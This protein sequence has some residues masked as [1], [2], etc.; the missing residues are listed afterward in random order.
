MELSDNVTVSVVEALDVTIYLEWYDEAVIGVA[1]DFAWF[2][3][4]TVFDQIGGM[5][6]ESPVALTPLLNYTE[7]IL[8]IGLSQ[9]PHEIELGVTRVTSEIQISVTQET[10]DAAI[11]LATTDADAPILLARETDDIV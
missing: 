1:E 8:S 10:T 11:S 7:H 6:Q 9:Q 4:P 3:P 5:I 2:I